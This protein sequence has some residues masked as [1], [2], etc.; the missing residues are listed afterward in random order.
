MDTPLVTL[1]IPHYRTLELAQLCLRSIRAYTQNVPFEA[2]VIDNGSGEGPALDYLRSVEWIRLIERTENIGIKQKA[3]KEAVDMAIAE[4][5]APYVL[6]MH[7]DTIPIRED[8][9]S[10]HVQKLESDDKLAAIGTDRL[11]LRPI[12]QEV[13]RQVE[14]WRFWKKARH[15]R[16][17][18]YVRSHCALYRKSAL[19]ELGLCYDDPQND[20]AGRSIVLGLEA[21]GYKTE[22]LSVPEV[23][24]RV[25]HL[26]HGTMVTLPE[27]GARARTIRRGQ[28]R[29]TKFLNQPS[30]DN[31]WKD[32]SLD[33]GTLEETSATQSAYRAAG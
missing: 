15:R 31:I 10:W 25:V 8:W 28:R 18:P 22:L 23:L 33:H 20:V 19:Q 24:K 32:E 6:A 13:L 26:D 5:R 17:D 21:N 14:D 30:V 7:T 3:H 9:L 27:L 12:W 2:L 4:S 29:I 16:V 11:K 1:I